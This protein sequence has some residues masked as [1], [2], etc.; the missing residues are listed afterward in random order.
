[1]AP[2]AASAR[3][4][5]RSSGSAVTIPS[6]RGSARAHPGPARRRGAT[7]IPAA[8]LE[9]TVLRERR[10]AP[11]FANVARSPRTRARDDAR[12]EARANRREALGRAD[13]P[14]HHFARVRYAPTP[15][16]RRGARARRGPADVPNRGFWIFWRGGSRAACRPRDSRGAARETDTKLARATR[17]SSANRNRRRR[18]V[19]SVPLPGSR[20]L[21]CDRRVRCRRCPF[22]R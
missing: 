10:V 15:R 12:V 14:V 8:G 1:M 2:S 11:F 21:V 13:A 19:E 6:S 16:A 3:S 5:A 7:T 22:H 4:S 20:T 9:E 17:N 18:S